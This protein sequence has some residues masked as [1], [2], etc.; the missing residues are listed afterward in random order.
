IAG[1]SMNGAPPAGCEVTDRSGRP[2]VLIVVTPLCHAPHSPGVTRPPARHASNHLPILV[3]LNVADKSSDPRAPKKPPRNP[4]LVGFL[5]EREE[6]DVC[7]RSCGLHADA[8]FGPTTRHD[9]GNRA[10]IPH[11]MAIAEWPGAR[12]QQHIE[13]A[14]RRR[15]LFA[16]HPA[17][18]GAQERGDA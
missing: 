5:L 16:V 2:P 7:L 4:H 17:N 13:G 8:S 12:P 18:S 14:P 9:R 15:S 1:V 11:D 10:V 6:P 3:G